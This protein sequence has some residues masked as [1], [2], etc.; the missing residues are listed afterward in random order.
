M[1]LQQF[2]CQVHEGDV[3]VSDEDV[4]QILFKELDSSLPV[5]SSNLETAAFDHLEDLLAGNFF[6]IATRSEVLAKANDK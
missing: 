2:S 4:G 5:E 3:E 1:E 6:L